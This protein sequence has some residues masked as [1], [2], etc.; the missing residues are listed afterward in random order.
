MTKKLIA[1]ATLLVLAGIAQIG[2]IAAQIPSNGSGAFIHGNVTDPS[3]AVIPAAMVTISTSQWSR[4]VSTDEAGQYSFTGLA[5]GHYRVRVHFGGF[6]A[7]DKS[8]FVVT[9]GHETEVN[10]QLELREMRQ[11]VSVFE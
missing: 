1:G 5:P 8:N 9:Q 4:T 2:M 6:A 3:G 11:A 7:F 10:A